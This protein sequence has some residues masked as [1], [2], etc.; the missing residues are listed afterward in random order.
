MDKQDFFARLE[1]MVAVDVANEI[2][3][4][5]DTYEEWIAYYGE[6]R[7][8]ITDNEVD[9]SKDKLRLVKS[10]IE[11]SKK[12]LNTIMIA[13]ENKNI[14]DLE[15]IVE[16]IKKKYPNNPLIERA[17]E[18]IVNINELKAQVQ[19]IEDERVKEAIK[20]IN[21]Y[22]P[23][24]F[25]EK[26]GEEFMK[27]CCSKLLLDFDFVK[28]Y[29]EPKVTFDSE[30]TEP[31]DIPR[32]FT[33][34]FFWGT[35]SSGK[36]CALAAMLKTIEDKYLPTDPIM[37]SR[38]LGKSYRNEL[39]SLFDKSNPLDNKCLAVK[40]MGGWAYLPGRTAEERTQYMPFCLSR[41]GEP[42]RYRKIAFLEL[43]GEIFKD[44]SV[45]HA[46]EKLA[47]VR[48]AAFD[49]LNLVLNSNNHKI[50]FFFVDY[51]VDGIG[52]QRR[53][54]KDA[55]EY[56]KKIDI[57]RKKTDAVYIV[58]TKAD[59][60]PAVN[61]KERSK[62]AAKF[63]KEH[64]SAFIGGIRGQC[65][66]HNIQ[67]PRMFIFSIGDV[68]FKRICKINTKYS[69]RII[70]ELLQHVVPAGWFDPIDDIFS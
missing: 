34:I 16:T 70:N 2:M 25:L 14:H 26:K 56:F 64:Y 13:V 9:F 49:K 21:E 67:G 19:V 29:I 8:Y 68:Y 51:S 61:D 4:G 22:P 32:G 42:N 27:K 69:E 45:V 52:E 63:L 43:S 44:I 7:T 15:N 31:N 10:I 36:T 53:Y 24:V 30:L 35:T 65:L 33:D 46:G 60:I 20:N 38:I 17:S 62:V 58:L 5:K 1:H 3:I 41:L 11:E 6:M 55:T 37:I 57:F 18:E 12:L 50:H 28:D 40:S 66:R 54:L 39:T 59:V 48:Q 47:V 23:S